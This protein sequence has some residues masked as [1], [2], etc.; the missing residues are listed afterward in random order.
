MGQMLSREDEDD[1]DQPAEDH[2]V[3]HEEK[4]KPKPRRRCAALRSRKTKP[5]GQGRTRRNRQTFDV[6]DY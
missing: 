4:E 5:S 6:R 3:V 1:Y 2:E